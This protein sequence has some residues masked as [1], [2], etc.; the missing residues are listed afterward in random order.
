MV[1]FTFNETTLHTVQTNYGLARTQTD[2]MVQKSEST[3]HQTTQNGT[4]GKEHFELLET[5]S[6]ST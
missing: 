4:T 5:R 6:V 1:I 3:A 2:Y